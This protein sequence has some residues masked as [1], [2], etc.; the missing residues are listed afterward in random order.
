MTDKNMHTRD[1]DCT[2]VDGECVGC[3]V[4]HNMECPDCG[5]WGFHKPA[6]PDMLAEIARDTAKMLE[7]K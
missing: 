2:V 7:A 4:T 1:E 5:G 3:G 6:C